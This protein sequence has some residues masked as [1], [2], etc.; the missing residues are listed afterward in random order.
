MEFI[1]TLTEVIWIDISYQ[2]F[3]LDLTVDK[4]DWRGGAGIGHF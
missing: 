2:Y 1:C 3:K 4:G